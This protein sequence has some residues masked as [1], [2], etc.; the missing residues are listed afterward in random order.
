MVD[1]IWGFQR[2][3]PKY[4]SHIYSF[5]NKPFTSR[6]IHKFR[7]IYLHFPM[8]FLQKEL[9]K[10]ASNTWWDRF[11]N[12]LVEIQWLLQLSRMYGVYE[13]YSFGLWNLI[14]LNNIEQNGKV[15]WLICQFRSHNNRRRLKNTHS[16]VLWCASIGRAA[17]EQW[18]QQHRWWQ[19]IR[20]CI[21]QFHQMILKGNRN[22][23]MSL[24]YGQMASDNLEY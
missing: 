24:H 5:S 11:V 6:H 20:D 8:K 3:K 22:H 16:S 18:Q 19:L 7:N 10:Y 2:I 9:F 21:G 23:V 12:E 4:I 15:L 14:M 17:Y 13:F 1:A